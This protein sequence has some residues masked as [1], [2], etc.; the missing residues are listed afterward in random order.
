MA[1]FTCQSRDALKGNRNALKHGACSAETLALKREIQALARL[2][3]E[4]M[5]AMGIAR[6]KIGPRSLGEFRAVAL[7]SSMPAFR[8][9]L[10]P[11]ERPLDRERRPGRLSSVGRPA[12]R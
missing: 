5:R 11:A 9:P 2:A 6:C 3:S 7:A 8:L 12:S 4:A 10:G 1:S